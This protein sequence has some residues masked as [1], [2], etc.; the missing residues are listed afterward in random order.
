MLDYSLL[1]VGLL[2]ALLLI[3]L[4]FRI[5]R[6]KRTDLSPLL[7]K[8]DIQETWSEKL[9][10]G[11]LA[12][13]GQN[14]EEAGKHAGE[15]RN[16]VQNRFGQFGD[17]IG[18]KMTE[19]AQLQKSQLET[20]STKLN[21]NLEASGKK[22][23]SMTGALD[24]QNEA[25]RAKL[26]EKLNELTKEN[27][28]KLDE[29]R[30]TVD[31]KLQGTLEK[32]L[33]E[34]FKLVS[35]RLEQVHRGL[36]EM[37]T[38]AAGVGDL[39]R[40]LTNVKTR[41]GWGEI[42]LGAVLAEMMTPEQ[43]DSNVAVRKNSGERVEFAI[44]LPGKD[45]DGE[46][47]LLPI[48]AKFPKE[49]Y[50]RLVDAAEIA[51]AKGVERAAKQLEIRIKKS[52]KDISDKYIVPP[53]TTDFAIMFLPTEGLFAEIVRRPG[54]VDTLQ[55]E[56]RVVVVGP[57]TF[58]AFLNSLQM[59]FRTL[60][61]QQRSSEVWEVLGAVKTEFGKFGD[62]LGKVKKKL[63]EATNHMDKV[64]VRTRQLG[65]KLREV[66]EL[67]QADVENVLQLPA[68]DDEIV[69]EEDFMDDDNGH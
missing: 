3:F 52:A 42:Q 61:I 59:G 54:L 64:D 13:L 47:V 45:D 24:N 18:Q 67:P 32:R 38:L 8:F 49:D 43:Y 26:D 34:S 46:H 29:M 10:R 7:S 12:Q 56:H 11:V 15:L 23:T 2:N 30:K 60:A 40:V 14:R 48:D 66:E 20:F 16:E 55:R 63:V 9:E 22:L 6:Y 35:E 68:L 37:Q 17:S 33:G 27:A 19:I 25:L 58:T 44:K 21:E 53:Q 1:I 65:R 36:G 31:E 69:T 51:D 62:T 41:G 28:K 5:N 57:T 4:L 39:K 50:E